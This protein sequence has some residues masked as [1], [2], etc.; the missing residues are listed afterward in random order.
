VFVFFSINRTFVMAAPLDQQSRL[1]PLAWI[2]IGALM[3][4]PAATIAM[5]RRVGEASA[6]ILA[7]FEWV[8]A[9][10]PLLVSYVALFDRSPQSLVG[11]AFIE[12]VVLMALSTRRVRRAKPPTADG[13]VEGSPR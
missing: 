13:S 11:L 8:V 3:C 9:S 5:R 2:T 4:A 12:A 1:G 10:A 6:E 7:V